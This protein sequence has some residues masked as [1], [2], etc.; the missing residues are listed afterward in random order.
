MSI[1]VTG[2]QNRTKNSAAY[3]EELGLMLI[4]NGEEMPYLLSPLG[5]IIPAGITEPSAIPTVAD[6]GAGSLTNGKWVIY[7]VVYVME[8]SFPLVGARIFSNPSGQSTPFQIGVTGG[9]TVGTRALDVTVTGSTNPFVTDVYLYRTALQDTQDDAEIAADAGALFFIDSITNAAGSLVIED[10]VLTN[11]GNEVVDFTN[12]TVPQFKFCVWDGSYFWGF[13]NHPF[14]ADATWDMTGLV[15][16]QNPDEKFYAGRDGQ[17]L[18]F[19]SV[20][21]GGVDNRGTFFFKRIDDQTGQAVDGDGVDMT[22]PADGMGNIVVIGESATLYRSAYRNPFAWGYMKN[23]AGEYIPTQWALKVSGALGTAIAVTPEQQ[24]LK[25]DMELPALCLTYSLQTADTEV[26]AQTRR[27]ISR[28]HSVTSHFS[29]FVAI[30]KGRQVLWGFDA[31][32]LA[33]LESD[34]YT[35]VPVSGPISILLRE[36][37]KNRSLHLLAHGVYDPVT[38]I[39]AMWLSSSAM[40]EDDAPAQ[41][42]ICIYQHAPTGFWGTFTD[43]GILCSAALEDP[44]TSQRNILVGTENGFLGKAFDITT[45]GNWLPVDSI[46]SGSIRSATP[47]TITRSEGQDDFNTLSAGIVGNFCMVTN[48]DGSVTQIRKIT[49]VTF[50]TLTFSEPMNPIPIVTADPGLVEEDQAWKFF[51]GLIELRVLKYFDNGEP[52]ADKAPREYWATLSDAELALIEYYPEHSDALSK[53]VILQQDRESDAW[54]N[55]QDFPS[56]KTKTFGLALVERSYEPTKLYNFTL[57]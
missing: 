39:N 29:Q 37:S 53:T 56:S 45:Y 22:I 16:L 8:N 6:T 27:Q 7:V 2:L 11:I 21:S 55:K 24:L 1:L 46:Y 23:I 3:S 54:F 35:Q 40:D 48:Y 26:F 17:Y 18:T 14:S 13:A 31:K 20:A 57:K 10:N 42:D 52:A 25:L 12:F 4:S 44:I 51:I 19:S 34:G 38:E 28:L 15:T 47:T 9:V 30:S 43:L 36:L 41:F 49:A 32:N 5:E 33:I 50:D